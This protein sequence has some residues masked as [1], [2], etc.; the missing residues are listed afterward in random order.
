MRQ[1]YSFQVQDND[2]ESLTF[3][4]I[5]ESLG[6]AKAKG[7]RAGYSELLLLEVR[8]LMGV[9]LDEVNDAE[10][11]A[12]PF[13]G[14]DWLPLIEAIAPNLTAEGVGKFWTLTIAT[15]PFTWGYHKEGVPEGKT[16]F[17]QA[18]NE[19]DGSLHL[20][21]GTFGLI[22]EDNRPAL[23]YLEFSGWNPPEED[24][25][26]HYRILEPGWNPRHALQVS[27]QAMVQV[28]GVTPQD[29]FM[30]TGSAAKSIID[31][32]RFDVGRWHGPFQLQHPAYALKG[33]HE[34][35]WDEPDEATKERILNQVFPDVPTTPEPEDDGDEG[36]QESGDQPTESHSSRRYTSWDLEEFLPSLFSAVEEEVSRSLF[37]EFAPV[38][39]AA[40][41]HRF[42]Q[43]S[44]VALGHYPVR[45]SPYSLRRILEHEI[46]NS[47][48]SSERG[49]PLTHSNQLERA[50][51]VLAT[52]D[53]QSIEFAKNDPCALVRAAAEFN[54]ANLR[55]NKDNLV[56]LVRGGDLHIACTCV[57]SVTA[58]RETMGY[59]NLTVPD[60]GPFA[61]KLVQTASK[62]WSTALAPTRLD[63]YLLTSTDS[64]LR[65]PVPDHFTVSHHGHGV[66]S[67]ALTLRF[68]VGDVAFVGRVYFGGLDRDAGADR[69]HWQLLVEEV[70][71]F[72][73]DLLEQFSINPEEPQPLQQR[74]FLVV[75]PGGDFSDSENWTP[76]EEYMNGTWRALPI[77]QAQSPSGPGV[78]AQISRL[79]ES[80]QALNRRRSA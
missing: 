16:H 13:L 66:N 21:L 10:V 64:Y 30:P 48:M 44:R 71:P 3:G 47:V 51:A 70:Q 78:Q 43:F 57:S 18:I 45:S 29:I 54:V 15:P 37:H 62:T 79:S 38:D 67:Y 58:M 41:K 4:C 6:E 49:S 76:V 36:P 8:N 33:L 28:F 24:L 77:E 35:S 61:S 12:N 80:L 39:F 2:P 60:P 20:E 63:D 34:L 5:A 75:Y 7:K 42:A 55:S 65:G 1:V 69:H 27:L 25:P 31:D 59:E 50:L 22:Q 72:F 14:P 19:A 52:R 68:A 40:L 74:R 32:P 11:L 73:D 53:S 9:E 26:I 17:L 56:G 46:F 23:R